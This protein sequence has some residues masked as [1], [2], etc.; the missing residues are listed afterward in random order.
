MKLDAL[1]RVDRDES[2]NKWQVVKMDGLRYSAGRR[3]NRRLSQCVRN[4]Y[5][6]SL[7]AVS[8]THL[9]VYKR[10]VQG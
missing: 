4:D 1:K 5:M 9:D 8:Y 2:V 10:Q 3:S 7:K 6:D